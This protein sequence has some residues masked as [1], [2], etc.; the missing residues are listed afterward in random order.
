[1][2]SHFILEPSWRRDNFKNLLQGTYAREN[3][4]LW[5]VFRNSFQT[6]NAPLP[7]TWG[8]YV[9]VEGEGEGTPCLLYSIYFAALI[10]ALK[11]NYFNLK[12]ITFIKIVAWG[13]NTKLHTNMRPQKR[14]KSINPKFLLFWKNGDSYAVRWSHKW[15][16]HIWIFIYFWKAKDEQ[17]ILLNNFVIHCVLAWFETS[18]SKMANILKIILIQ[19]Y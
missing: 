3:Q 11:M 7:F 15:T 4:W 12:L 2:D 17:A 6:A 14:R 9:C 5:K 8:K 16:I 18:L 10:R 13:E 19:G 1:M